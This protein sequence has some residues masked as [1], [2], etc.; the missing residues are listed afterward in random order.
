[1]NNLKNSWKIKA[2]WY[3]IKN[4]LYESLFARLFLYWGNF[5]GIQCWCSL[6]WILVNLLI[7]IYLIF[8]IPIQ[9]KA[10]QFQIK[11]SFANPNHPS[12]NND[13]LKLCST[14]QKKLISLGC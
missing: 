5:F 4:K 1:M 14:F 3:N 2:D 10:I 13:H 7:S 11:K 8:W 6:N 9:P 12:C